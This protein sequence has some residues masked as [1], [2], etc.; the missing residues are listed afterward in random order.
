MED[1]TRCT[2]D[3]YLA[4]QNEYILLLWSFFMGGPL[5]ALFAVHN[6][7]HWYGKYQILSMPC[8]L[9]H[10]KSEECLYTKADLK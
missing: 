8:Q 5:Q 3:K 2:S 9:L 4:I 1:A 7:H 10:W 6:S